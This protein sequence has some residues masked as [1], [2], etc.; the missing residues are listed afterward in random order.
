MMGEGDDAGTRGG[1]DAGTRRGGETGKGK[2]E[3]TQ[4]SEAHLLE[5]PNCYGDG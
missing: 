3:N 2:R 1:G 5:C 4:A